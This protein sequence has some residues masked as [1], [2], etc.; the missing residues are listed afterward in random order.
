[1]LRRTSYSPMV[2]TLKVAKI[3]IHNSY[4]RADMQNDLA[5]IMVSTPILFNKWVR[6]TCLPGPMKTTNGSDWIWGPETGTICT[7]VGWGSV[8][9]K[10]PDRKLIKFFFLEFLQKFL[11]FQLII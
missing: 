9:E 6:P 5:L 11:F 2:Q 8:R 4:S 1:M 7:V 10:G 3:V